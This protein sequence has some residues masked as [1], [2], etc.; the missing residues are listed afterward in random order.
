MK[1]HGEELGFRGSMAGTPDITAEAG[2]DVASWSTLGLAGSSAI[3]Q[4]T[5]RYYMM[6]KHH[7]PHELPHH[8]G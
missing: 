4:H 1:G 7:H 8:N 3:T 5:L 2:M 6:V